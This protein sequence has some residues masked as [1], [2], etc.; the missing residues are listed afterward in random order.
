MRN[1]YSFIVIIL[2]V[3]A[4]IL[5]FYSLLSRP[6]LLSEICQNGGCEETSQLTADM[7]KVLVQ[8]EISIS[9]YTYYKF[10]LDLLTVIVFT[11]LAFF[12]LARGSK[13]KM[14]M[15]TSV[16][17]LYMGTSFTV[18]TLPLTGDV[19]EWP[20]K[21]HQLIAWGLFI[22]FFFLFPNGKPTPKWTLYL[23]F[24]WITTEIPY[25]LFPNSFLNSQ[26][27]PPVL[28]GIYFFGFLFACIFAQIFRYKKAATSIEKLQIKWFIFAL[29]LF[30]GNIFISGLTGFLPEDSHPLFI[31]IFFFVT[32]ATQALAL[33]LIPLSIA[34][35]ILKYRLWQIDLILSRTVTYISLTFIVVCFYVLF[36]NGLGALFRDPNNLVISLVSTGIIAVLFQPLTAY[37]QRGI[38]RLIYGDRDEP[39]KILARLADQLEGTLPIQRVLP[40]VLETT[41]Q[42]LK[43]PFIEITL[44]NGISHHLGTA[45][46]DAA[47]FPLLHQGDEI[48]LL[49]VGFRTVHEAFSKRD[50]RVLNH[51][52]KQIG[53]AAH[54]VLINTELQKSREK[55]V[56]TREEERRRLRR[57]LHDGV[58][59][60]LAAQT[61]KVGVAKQL[62]YD[63]PKAA[64]ELLSTLEEDLG[65]TLADIRH[66]IYNLRPPSLDDLG[67]LGAVREFAAQVKRPNG[68]GNPFA[69]NITTNRSTFT[70][71]A[72]VEVAAFRIIQEAVTNVIRHAQASS[73]RV[74]F[75]VGENGLKILIVDNGKGIAPNAK[76]GVGLSSMKERA[77]EVG[78]TC[79]IIS[80]ENKGT[81]LEVYLPNMEEGYGINKGINC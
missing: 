17:M 61:I 11:V 39:L 30:V 34:Y 58:G 28:S 80:A 33:C 54:S 25:A 2:F 32:V 13:T 63:N 43:L 23:S 37:L 4:L 46:G 81:R 35:A 3:A 77:E 36:V 53:I 47:I 40:T 51:L 1:K 22:P 16:L 74:E 67:L 14:G 65:H 52:A 41:M 45:S 49:K 15:Y 5:S 42:A 26:T 18:G 56:S 12:I 71:S 9:F 68:V 64:E 70:L 8:A 44:K 59:P 27:W 31:S 7:A 78:G 72:A 73:C 20:V 69:I 38:N 6:S 50:L 79:H 75:Q 21:F 55:L 19:W 66:I 29:I 57:D 24:L 60:S 48:G 10:A 76:R 62:L